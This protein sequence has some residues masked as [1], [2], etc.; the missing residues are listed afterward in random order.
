MSTPGILYVTMQPKESLPLAQFHEWYNNEHGPIRLRIPSIF[1]NGF[2]YQSA[3]GQKPTYMAIYDVTSM[4]LLETDTYTSLRE[5]RSNRESETIGQVDVKRY[6]YDLVH[7]K[8]SPLFAPIESLTDDEAEGLV[9]VAVEISLKDAS[10]AAE[11]YRKWHVEEH[12]DMLS[13]VPGW[14]RS[15]FFK[16]SSVENP[17]T[18]TYLSLHD[19]AKVNGLGGPE[20]KAAMD[21]Q[22]RN[23]V[24]ETCVAK[25]GRQTFSLFYVF[26]PAPRDLAP[27]RN[28]PASAAFTSPDKSTSTDPCT[29]PSLSSYIT[30]TDGTILPFRLEGNSDQ[31]APTIAF[32][33][34]LL[35]S[36]AMWDP[37]VKL[38]KE[39]RPDLRILRHDFRGR[40]ATSKPA[41]LE[42]V[43]GDLITV[44]DALRIPKL[45]AL[46]GVSMGGVNTLNFAINHPDRLKKFIACDFGPASSDANTQAWKDRI[47]VARSDNGKGINTL[48]D[49]TVARW[50]HPES[51]KRPELVQW[52][53]DL[54]A[55]NDV[56]GFANSCTV[57]WDYDLKPSLKSCKVPGLLV[58]GE[59]D[60][61]GAV[62]K[63]MEGFK[64]SVGQNG[65]ELRIVP[66]T[67]HLPMC[68]DTEAFWKHVEDSV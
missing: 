49:Q 6:F 57:L 39:K 52:V 37:F 46:I 68:E 59:N 48:A 5:T 61:N 53:T 26:G 3:D 29:D 14:L 55:T 43:T 18:F 16:T 42:H 64:D 10:D 38:L 58:V 20:H 23:K 40:N 7:T 13:K 60:A 32:C 4:P 36:L 15:R 41:R 8:Q 21:T 25:K 28:L 24:A 17:G 11:D 9:T 56:E 2:R 19:Y 12:A 27:L 51:M 65:V 22:W 44:L 35:T 47:D 66:G 34:S 33:N 30:A 67:G 63:A 45:E 31:K 54:V 1:T 50:F 62:V